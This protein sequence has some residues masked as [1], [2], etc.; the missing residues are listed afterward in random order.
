[1]KWIVRQKSLKLTVKEGFLSHCGDLLAGIELAAL[2]RTSSRVRAASKRPPIRAELRAARRRRVSLEQPLLLQPGLDLE[3]L[4]LILRAVHKHLDILSGQVAQH[5]LSPHLQLLLQQLS[6]LRTVAPV[7]VYM[8]WARRGRVVDQ[9]DRR[10]HVLV[11]AR[12]LHRARDRVVR[13]EVLHI[14][15]GEK[16]VHEIAISGENYLRR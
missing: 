6:S 13:D 4:L 5:V 9:Q 3:K 14:L 8:N 10:H 1:M 11:G 12:A 7:A 16:L 2:V 15:L